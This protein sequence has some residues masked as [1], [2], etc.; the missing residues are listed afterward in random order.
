MERYGFSKL[1]N[2]SGIF[3]GYKFGYR[4]M[5]GMN[6]NEIYS[7]GQAIYKYDGS[8]WKVQIGGQPDYLDIKGTSSNNIYTVGFHGTLKKF[9]GSYWTPIGGF[10]K[11]IVDFYSIMP[12]EEEIFVT[13]LQQGIGYIVRGKL[14]E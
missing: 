7:V 13:G 6:E 4:A 3:D 8:E 9:D 10:S 12:F 2:I 1:A 5:W 11:Y 14:I